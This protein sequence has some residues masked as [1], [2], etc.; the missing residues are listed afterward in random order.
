M[1]DSTAAARPGTELVRLTKVRTAL[2]IGTRS[3]MGTAIGPGRTD[4]TA[5]PGAAHLT[6]D[7]GGF[8]APYLMGYVRRCAPATSRRSGC[9]HAVRHPRRR[10][11]GDTGSPMVQGQS[12]SSSQ[13]RR[14]RPPRGNCSLH[15]RDALDWRPSES[16]PPLPVAWPSALPR[17]GLADRAR[18]R[19]RT[20]HAGRRLALPYWPGSPGELEV[21]TGADPRRR[22]SDGNWRQTTADR[23]DP[24]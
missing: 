3:G 4:S 18:R 12:S 19:A 6:A 17:S 14:P 16:S 11:G 21:L 23:T 9:D 7:S 24:G 15:R 8:D 22:A 20:R 13:P 5:L 2:V 1:A 10:L